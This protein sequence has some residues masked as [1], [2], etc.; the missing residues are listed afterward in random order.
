MNNLILK[1]EFK[2]AGIYLVDGHRNVA[3]VTATA[4]Y[5]P[6]ERFKEIFIHVSELAEQYKT[7]KLVFDK[8]QLS[9]FHQPSMEWYFVDWKEKMFDKGLKIHRKILPQD[10]VFRQSVRIARAKIAASYPLKKF[11]SMDI[12]Y[13][14][15]LEDAILR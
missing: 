4:A 8:R 13:M 2:H 9:V 5:I 11:N 7:A 10:D 15:S 12:Q 1:K 3:V 6:L 14:D